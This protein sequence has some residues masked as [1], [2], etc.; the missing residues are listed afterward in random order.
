MKGKKDVDRPALRSQRGG[1]CGASI[2]HQNNTH[3]NQHLHDDE[4]ANERKEGVIGPA[5]KR[6]ESPGQC[7]MVRREGSAH[8]TVLCNIKQSLVICNAEV[9]GLRALIV[10]RVEE[11]ALHT[12]AHYFFATPNTK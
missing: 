12:I 3:K 1:N 5:S 10:I 8:Q 9:I 4:G 7:S 11:S 2:E 6:R